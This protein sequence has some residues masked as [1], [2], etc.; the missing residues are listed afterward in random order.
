MQS[1]KRFRSYNIYKPAEDTF[2]LADALSDARGDNA[3]EIGTGSGYIASILARNFKNVVATDIDTRALLYAKSN[4]N[5][6]KISY[7]CCDA[8]DAIIGMK[9]D[10]IAI[11]PPYM[12]SDSIKD[13]SIDGGNGGI[14]VAISMLKCASRLLA[15]H[16][17]IYMVISSLA[18]Y[19]SLISFIKDKLGLDVLIIMKRAYWF[20]ELFVIKIFNK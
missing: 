2:L 11:N 5:M 15:D 13:R 12:P 3:L 17:A 10:L 18:D 20:E 8:A 9:F 7:I 4:Y 16:G 6:D 14:E 1:N 19:S